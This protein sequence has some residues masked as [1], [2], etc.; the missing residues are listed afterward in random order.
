MELAIVAE[1]GSTPTRTPTSPCRRCRLQRESNLL[2]GE[3]A[4]LYQSSAFRSADLRL[5]SSC[6]LRGASARERRKY[7]MVRR[8]RFMLWSMIPKRA[9]GWNGESS[10]R[11]GRGSR[12]RA[13]GDEISGRTGNW[14]GDLDFQLTFE[15]PEIRL[16]SLERWVT[17]AIVCSTTV[18]QDQTTRNLLKCCRS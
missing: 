8:S 16:L 18:S 6:L 1:S 17:S 12:P 3:L 9:R 4:R 7:S 10:Y 2:V 15:R 11:A 13:G 5:C 14:R